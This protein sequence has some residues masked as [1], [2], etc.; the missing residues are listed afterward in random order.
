MKKSKFLISLVLCL[1]IVATCLVCAV[2]VSA[3]EVGY[4][5]LYFIV[6]N[7]NFTAQLSTYEGTDAKVVIPEEVHG[8]KVTSIAPRVFYENSAIEQVEIPDTVT[9]IGLYAFAFCS[10]LKSVS[11]GSSVTDLGDSVFMNC[12]SLESAEINCNIDMLP[13]STFDRCSSLTDVTLS[14]SIQSLG[15]RAFAECSELKNLPIDT[16]SAIGSNCFQ[17]TGVTS[18]M[19]AEGVTG[20][21]WMCFAQC[22]NLE[23]ITIPKTVTSI[24]DTAF[25]EIESQITIKCWYETAAYQFAKDN[26]IPY[27]LLDG[28]KLGDANGDG[29]VNI[30]DVTAIQRF[31]A[32]M[33]VIEGINLHAADVNGDG[34]VTIEDATILQRFFAEYDDIPYSIGEVM[35]Q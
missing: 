12:T 31:K 21:P 35:T 7:D 11:L 24:S 17:A 10:N 23:E 26:N 28:A 33:E 16:I 5:N 20:V 25:Y 2:P 34:N 9:S 19:L 29:L 32:D 22:S 15:S 18:V 6:N 27:I 3:A 4:G 1:C 8:Y 14:D 13:R 30:N